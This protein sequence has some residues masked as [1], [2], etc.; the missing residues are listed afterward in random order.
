M[1]KRSCQNCL[2]ADQCPSSRPCRHFSPVDEDCD[3]ATEELIRKGYE[4]FCRE[5]KAYLVDEKPS[6]F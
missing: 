3:D 2:F 5:W 4:Q 6:D 1:S